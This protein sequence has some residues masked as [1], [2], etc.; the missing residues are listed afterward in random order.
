VRE[1]E[2]MPVKG[3]VGRRNIRLELSGGGAFVLGIAITANQQSVSISDSCGKIIASKRLKGLNLDNPRELAKQAGAAAKSLAAETVP[4]RM[5]LAGCGV[6]VGGVADPASGTVIRSD[7]LGWNNVPLA[8]MLSAELDMPVQ[9]EGRAVALLQAEQKGGLIGKRKNVVLISNGLWVGGAM[10]LD[11]RVVKGH[12][13][14]TGQI[15]HFRS[16]GDALCACGRRGCLD[17]TASG[18]SILRRLE[19]L[20]L[21]AMTGKEEAS[22]QLR[23]LTK[24]QDPRVRAAFRQAGREMGH[25]VDA[26]LAMLDPQLILFTGAT[27]RQ[28]DYLKGVR[29]TLAALRPGEEDWPLAISRATSGKAA[30]WLGLNAFIYSERL[31]IDRLTGR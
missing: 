31:D 30:I 9:L 29:E 12:A 21:V 11:G 22:G 20:D 6:A 18:L 3:K 4:D 5:R 28:E 19:G 14:M 1:G 13:N 15:G 10:M 17:A 8:E 26:I 16:G 2:A 24:S 25:A 23:A 7:P 27:H